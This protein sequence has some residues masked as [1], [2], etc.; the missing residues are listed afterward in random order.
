VSVL[1]VEDEVRVAMFLVK[2]LYAHGYSVDHVTSGEDALAQTGST[3]FS[4]V[5]LDLGLPDLDGLDVLRRLRENGDQTP[6]IVLTARTEP[7]DRTRSLE[8]GA[9]DF[10]TKPFV[11]SDLL[12][13]IRMHMD[14]E[15]DE[16]TGTHKA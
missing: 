8:L 12:D 7:R 15:G 3:N 13:R 9:T 5:L 10:V 16:E 6:V 14:V 2:G 11:F 1:L 4:L